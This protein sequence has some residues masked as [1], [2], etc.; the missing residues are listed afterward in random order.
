MELISSRVTLKGPLIKRWT[1]ASPGKT[2]IYGRRTIRPCKRC[3]KESK[4][5]SRAHAERSLQWN[6]R[7]HSLYSSSGHRKHRQ[8]DTLNMLDGNLKIS[9]HDCLEKQVSQIK[10]RWSA[11]VSSQKGAPISELWVAHHYVGG[12]S[13]PSQTTLP[14]NICS[15]YISPAILDLR[16][17]SISSPRLYQWR[18]ALWRLCCKWNGQNFKYHTDTSSSQKAESGRLVVRTILSN[19]TWYYLHGSGISEWDAMWLI[20]F[21]IYNEAASKTISETRLWDSSN[22]SLERTICFNSDV[23]NY[24][25][26]T[27]AGD[28]FIADAVNN[29]TSCT[30]V[31]SAT[32]VSFAPTIRDELLRRGMDMK[33]TK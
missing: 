12:L 22:K 28:N 21:F 8:N 2:A 16:T 19:D 9:S 15:R 33:P 25:L 30:E 7:T 29:I 3:C 1:K 5:E 23:D 11:F 31:P 13:R 14:W 4:L 27:Y 20:R 6:S 26:A 18:P 24:L 17:I 10:W 32:Y